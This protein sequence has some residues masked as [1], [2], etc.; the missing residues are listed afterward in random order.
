MAAATTDR[1]SLSVYGEAR[2]TIEG[3]PLAPDEL[4]RTDDYWRATPTSALG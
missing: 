3:A 2:S 1:E 4:R